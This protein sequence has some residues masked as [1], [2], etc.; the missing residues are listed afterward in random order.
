LKKGLKGGKLNLLTNDQIRDLHMATL[1]VLEQV[2]MYSESERILKIFASAGADVDLKNKSVRIPEHLVKEALNKAPKQIVLC[3]RNAEYDILV[4]DDRVYFGLGGTAY[5]YLIDFETGE[6][7]R[8]TKND[9]AKSSRLGDALENISF[10]MSLCGAF[11]MPLEVTFLHEFDAI[12]NNTEKPVIYPAPGSENAKMMLSMAAD[13][14]GGIDELRKRPILSLYSETVSPLTF[15]KF[16]DNMVEFAKAGV[17]IVLGPSP[18][19]GS[20]GPVT[21]AGTTIVS[22]A[23][24]LAAITLS[25]LVRPGTPIISCVRTGVMD[26]RTGQFLYAAPESSIGLAINAQLSHYY[27]LPAFGS[28]GCSDSKMLDAQ[29]AVEATSTLFMSALS[30]VNL[31]QT[32]GTIAGGAAGCM[33]LAVVC[34]EIIGMIQRILEGV[35]FSDEALAV[36][37]IREIGPRGHFLTHKHTFK[38]FRKEIYSPKIF[39]R[40]SVKAWIEK[41]GKD[42]REIAKDKVRKI[43]NEHYVEPLPKDIRRKLTDKLKAT[44]RSM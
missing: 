22:N 14:V 7:K 37:V 25:Q 27:G 5:P 23:E 35:N 2:G 26:L 3:G 40:C 24:N 17:P 33:E 16:N 38:F 1:E 43:L 41:G 44:E 28:G 11:D 34:D 13:V 32:C 15:C 21:V 12:I 36:D 19:C 10:I 9:V 30:G 42:I 4:E 20:T 39:D 8:G 6:F 29:A 18:V 31:I